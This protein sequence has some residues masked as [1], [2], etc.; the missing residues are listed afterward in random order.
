MI[1]YDEPEGTCLECFDII[2]PYEGVWEDNDQFC[3]DCWDN[4]FGK[5]S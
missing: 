5:E 3:V 4:I 2:E 1:D